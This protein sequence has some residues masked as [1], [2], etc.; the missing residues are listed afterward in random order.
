MPLLPKHSA[1]KLDL[2][3]D[4]TRVAKL[5]ALGDPLEPIARHIDFERLSA[6]T[7]AL[8]PRGDGKK[9]GRPPYPSEVML[10]ILVVKYLNGLSDEQMEFQLLDRMSYRRFCLLADSANV[11]DRNTLWHWQQRLGVDGT[12]ALFQAIDGQLL[13]RGYIARRGQII[14]ATLVPAPI[15]HFTKADKRQLDEGQIPSDWSQAKRRQ[16][17]LDATHTKKHGK[18]YHGYKL[19]ISVDVKHKFIRTIT[20]GTASEHDSTHFD[21]VLDGGNTSA[22]VYADKGYPS[23][24][25]SEML[26]VLGHREHIQRKAAKGKPLSECQ[27]G[28]NKR[29]AKTRARV[30]HAFAQL[31]HM[32][33][34][35]RTIGQARATAAMTMMATCYNIR[36]LASFLADGV[37]AFFRPRPSKSEVRLQGA[38]A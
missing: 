31:H 5:D 23:A 16:K 32:G 8:L 2:F 9:G 18:S 10:R 33:K 13:E 25:R 15:Q 11:P 30:E 24:A 7:D 29:I 28:R 17:D 26:Q 4:S 36:R 27:K 1:I 14:D 22:D 37:D 34:R 3:A 12:K 19:S 35:I 21:E 20:T 38:K 6:V